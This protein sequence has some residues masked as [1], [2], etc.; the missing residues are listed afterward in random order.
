MTR[1]QAN[2][3]LI[4]NSLV[5]LRDHVAA[6]LRALAVDG[7]IAIGFSGGVDSTALLLAVPHARALHID[8]GLHPDSAAWAEHARTMASALGRRFAVCRVDVPRSGSIENAARRAR[9]AALEAALE[10]GETLLTAHQR[11]DQTET[12]LLKLLRGAGPRGL[13]GIAP[14]RVLKSGARVVRPLLDVPRAQLA[15]VVSAAGFAPIIDPSNA[16][17]QHARSFLRHCVLPTLRAR[18][19]TLDQSFGASAR[20]LNGQ[21]ALIAQTLL[22]RGREPLRGWRPL[23]RGARI[24]LIGAWLDTF[25]SPL[26]TY[27]QLAQFAT[28]LDAPPD[29]SPMLALQHGSLRRYRD[30]IHWVPPLAPIPPYALT[31]DGRAVTLPHG[32]GQLAEQPLAAPLTIRSATSNETLQ[33]AA[34]RPHRALND[35]LHDAHIPPW[36]RQRLPRVW[37]GTTLLGVLGAAPTAALVALGLNRPIDGN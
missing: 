22:P 25:E 20:A 4:A 7:P 31:F 34:N 30:G 32:L 17:D 2:R 12:L 28:Q 19:A 26:P 6:R 18:F 8:H 23:D 3:E 21:R 16:D 24:A 5:L 33:V 11:E 29:R 37:S 27:A 9:Y 15:A 35:Y 10:P 14:A 36:L 13:R 1:P